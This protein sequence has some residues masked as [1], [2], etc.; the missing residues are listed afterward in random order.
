M[1]DITVP[2]GWDEWRLGRAVGDGLL[3]D[4]HEPLEAVPL[5]QATV[6]AVTA[7]LND[8]GFADYAW[9][10]IDSYHQWER[11]QWSELAG[12]LNSV[13]Y[14]LRQEAQAH[15]DVKLGLIVEGVATS[16][17]IGTQLWYRGKGKDVFYRTR[18]QSLRLSMIY[19]WLYQIG[20]FIE[21]MFTADYK[22]TCTFLVAAYQS[23]Q[24]E[25]HTTM[26][27]YLKPITWTPNIQV[28]ML[29]AI[30]NGVGIGEAKAQALIRK[31]GTVWQVLSADPKLLATTDGIGKAIATKVLR[32]IG[33]PDA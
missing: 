4:V 25:S 28:E 31:F 19:S 21:I 10:G 13:E 27:R 11:K 3:V 5:M 22:S 20:K 1:T 8:A 2:K 16:G 23:D 9:I 29:M 15:P 33:R 12:G 24:K 18:E 14:Q 7:P 32:K 6:P 30:G 26:Q 17:I